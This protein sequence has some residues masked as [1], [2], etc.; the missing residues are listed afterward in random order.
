MGKMNAGQVVLCGLLAGAVIFVG[1]FVLGVAIIARD[2]EAALMELGLGPLRFGP[3]TALLFGAIWLAMG[4]LAVWLYAAIRPRFGPGPRT[5]VYAG[6]F[7]WTIGVFFPTVGLVWLELLP[8]RLA[9]IATAWRL[10]EVPLATIAGA[11]VYREE[12]GVPAGA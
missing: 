1:E 12:A 9:V 8:V 7:I 10:I 5:A 6:L 3:A 11:R 4:V 2:F